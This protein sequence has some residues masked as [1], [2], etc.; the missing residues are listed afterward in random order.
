MRYLLLIICSLSITS[1]AS[2]LRKSHHERIAYVTPGPH[3]IRIGVID[4]GFDPSASTGH[5]KL[6]SEGHWDI[7]NDKVGLGSTHT[8]GTFVAE[9][10]AND[11]GNTDYCLVIITSMATDGTVWIP[12]AVDYLTSLGVKVIN[13]SL[14]G[15]YYWYEEQKSL[16]KF[17]QQ[18]GVAFVAAGNDR[19]NLSQVCNIYPTCYDDTGVIV[20][21]ATEGDVKSEHK[22]SYSNYG[23]KV[24]RWMNGNLGNDQGTSYAS[25]RALAQYALFLLRSQQ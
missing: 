11:M 17:H 14:S 19:Q 2:F 15:H 18:G 10:I 25:P 3:T 12:S 5:I 22:A 6:C 23:D 16:Q 7:P 8:H 24:K 4:T 21:G 1:F 13:I 20:V 9:I